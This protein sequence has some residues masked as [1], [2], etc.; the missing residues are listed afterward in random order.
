MKTKETWEQKL[1]FR[2]SVD[3][4]EHRNL[5]V[6][7]VSL[8][9]RKGTRVPQ[10]TLSPRLRRDEDRSSH[11]IPYRSILKGPKGKKDL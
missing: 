7:S 2:G 10:S 6:T 4:G 1:H 11:R 9:E 5:L 3:D 8:A